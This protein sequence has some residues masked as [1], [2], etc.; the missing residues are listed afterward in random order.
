MPRQDGASEGELE[1]RLLPSVAA[2]IGWGWGVGGWEG[3]RE[4]RTSRTIDDAVSKFDASG[5][6]DNLVHD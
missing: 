3:R 2:G 6:F 4:R 5:S 1:L